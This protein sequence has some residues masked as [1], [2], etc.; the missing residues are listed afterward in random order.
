MTAKLP[1]RTM[2]DVWHYALDVVMP[3]AI[4]RAELDEHS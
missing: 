3:D 2:V 4:A 1:E